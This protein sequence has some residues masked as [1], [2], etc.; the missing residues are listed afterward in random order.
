MYVCSLMIIVQMCD[1]KTVHLLTLVGSNKPPKV[2]LLDTVGD[3]HNSLSLGPV[4]RIPARNKVTPLQ[5]AK[6]ANKFVIGWI[7]SDC[8][9]LER[10]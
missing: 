9:W 8:R 6:A 10:V 2:V 4:A 1:S 3:M 7:C 5:C